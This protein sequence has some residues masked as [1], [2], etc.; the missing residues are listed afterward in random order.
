MEKANNDDDFDLVE[1]KIK[2]RINVKFGDGGEVAYD[3][4]FASTIDATQA[5]EARFYPAQ[6]KITVKEIS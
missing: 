4:F 1:E 2:C 6:C 3:G 5:A